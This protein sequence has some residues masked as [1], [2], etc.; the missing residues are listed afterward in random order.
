MSLSG[1]E[2]KN[3]VLGHNKHM[4]NG[5]ILLGWA[6]EGRL[7]RVTG[8]LHFFYFAK[9]IPLIILAPHD[10]IYYYAPPPP[11]YIIKNGLM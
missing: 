3:D 7:G 4:I 11:R 10:Q 9:F 2:L 5:R 8:N 6:L 1:E